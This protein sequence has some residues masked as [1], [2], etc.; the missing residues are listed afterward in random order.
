MREKKGLHTTEIINKVVD[1]IIVVMV[2]IVMKNLN[3]TTEEIK[4]IIAIGRDR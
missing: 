4:I 1:Y 2:L 3:L